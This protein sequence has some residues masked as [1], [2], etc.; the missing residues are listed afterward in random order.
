MEFNKIDLDYRNY[1]TLKLAGNLLHANE[2]LTF[3]TKNGSA[4]YLA[5]RD[6]VEEWLHP[7]PYMSIMTS[8][9][10]GK[11][12]V[13]EVA[14][15]HMLWSASQSAKYFNFQKG[16]SAL[17]SLPLTY[18]AGKMMVVRAFYSQLNLYIQ[19]PK[20]QA[21]QD[22][23]LDITIDFAPFTPMQLDIIPKN[24]QLPRKVLLGGG[25]VSKELED[26]LQDFQEEIYHG[27]GMAETL[28]HIALRRVNGPKRS[29][30][31]QAFSSV[32][33]RLDTRNCLCIQL[34]FQ[35]EEIST[36]DIVQMKGSHSFIWLGRIDNVINT[37][38]IKVFPEDIENKITALI[39][40]RFF[41]SSKKDAILGEKV[42]LILEKNGFT[43]DEWKI[44][45]TQL[46]S[47]LSKYEVPKE[48]YTANAFIETHSGKI[49]R[50][51]TLKISQKAI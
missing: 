15:N 5:L 11:P 37:G 14:K 28:S 46:Q 40:C 41:I 10:T 9:S 32:K 49:Q 6:F 34:P 12:K 21:L 50:E 20:T 39:S 35:K 22:L 25:P 16:Q 13:M 2:I 45:K 38:G 23:P 33:L 31:Y 1:T 4:P 30:I 51:A 17:L 7:S 43:L 3:C 29:E 48:V 24:V 47:V 8:G 44:L 18:I 27:Y 36:N 19:E 26:K 42:I